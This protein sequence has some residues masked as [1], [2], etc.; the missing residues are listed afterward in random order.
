MHNL[1]LLTIV[2][3]EKDANDHSKMVEYVRVKAK[4][5]GGRRG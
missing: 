5:L 3:A 1:V 2:V 4:E